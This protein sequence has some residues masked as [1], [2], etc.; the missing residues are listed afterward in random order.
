MERKERA[1]QKARQSHLKGA[2][3]K[4]VRA[5]SM[6]EGLVGG[7]A[8]EEPLPGVEIIRGIRG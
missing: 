4:D 1:K 7:H 8:D 5:C 2:I 3:R 6:S